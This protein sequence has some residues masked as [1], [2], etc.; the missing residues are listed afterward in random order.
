MTKVMATILM[1]CLAVWATCMFII[2]H[3]IYPQPRRQSEASLCARDL[4]YFGMVQ[5]SYAED[6]NGLFCGDPC[7]LMP[8]F[9]YSIYTPQS[10]PSVQQEAEV[11]IERSRQGAYV[12]VQGLEKN[13]ASPSV[14]SY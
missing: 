9:P 12:I 10:C 8:Y 1:C 2:P 14:L 11:R 6:H 3:W 5:M 4:M 7:D 13:S